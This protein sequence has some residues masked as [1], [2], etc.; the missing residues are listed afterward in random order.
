MEAYIAVLVGV[1]CGVDGGDI[2]QA[3]VNI[4]G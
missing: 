1:R 3:A 4:E 2:A